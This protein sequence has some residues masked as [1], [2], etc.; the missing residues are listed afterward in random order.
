MKPQTHVT[1]IAAHCIALFITPA[2]G[3]P[4]PIP[5]TVRVRVVVTAPQA[6]TDSRGAGVVLFDADA[7]P[8]GFTPPEGFAWDEPNAPGAIAIAL[9]THNPPPA[10]RE[11]TRDAEGNARAPAGWFDAS[12]NWYDRPQRELSVHLDATEVHNTLCPVEFRTGEPVALDITLAWVVGGATLDIAMDGQ[13]VLESHPLMG[14]RPFR[15]AGATGSG[16]T[17]TTIGPAT[18]EHAGAITNAHLAQP[19]R[20]RV[21]DEYFVHAGDRE[22]RTEVDFAGVPDRV[23]RVLATLTLSEPEVG[24][25]HWD[26]KGAIYL[27]HKAIPQDDLGPVRFEVLRF[28][29]PFRKGWTWTADVTHLL[30]VMNGTREMGCFIDTWMKGWLVSFDLDFYPG[31]PAREPVGV[32]PL[33]SGEIEIGNPDKPPSDFLGTR[34]LR[35]DDR[36]TH[37]EVLITAT[38]HGMSPNTDNAGEF[39][40]L[41]RTLTVTDHALAEI[42]E[43]NNLWTEDVYLNPCRP[44]GGTWKFDR[45]GWA[46]GSVVA[47]WRVDVSSLVRPGGALTVGYELDPYLNEGRGQ[48]WAPHH[49]TEGVLVYWQETRDE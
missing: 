23:A 29:T 5:E 27:W 39:M 47:P 37:A 22:P 42:A 3:E 19:V 30:P 24:Y 26:K 16:D 34:F 1:T 17:A 2:L 43:W 14:V 11:P 45:A 15:I 35:V 33:W 6:G 18:V 40:P 46:P 8:D 25:D 31:V 32:V 12:G 13:P 41:G 49:W 20:V 48:T 21:F 44:Q 9:D 36:A 4:G 10:E 38:G 28:I 7:H